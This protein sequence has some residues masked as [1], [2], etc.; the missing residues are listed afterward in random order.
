MRYLS[1]ISYGDIPKTQIRMWVTRDEADM[2][3][4]QAAGK[5]KKK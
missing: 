4:F 3:A 2:K 5:A 1:G